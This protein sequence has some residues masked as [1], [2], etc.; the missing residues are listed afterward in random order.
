MPETEFFL[1]EMND[2]HK[3]RDEPNDAV[4]CPARYESAPRSDLNLSIDKQLMRQQYEAL[5][6]FLRPIR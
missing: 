3:M 1:K 4:A 5:G 2:E 6:A